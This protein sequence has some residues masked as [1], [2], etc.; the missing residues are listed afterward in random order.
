MK[1]PAMVVTWREPAFALLALLL[2]V[3]A[4]LAVDGA[5]GPGDTAA[6]AAGPGRGAPRA[7]EMDVLLRRIEMRQ[8]SDHPARYAAPAE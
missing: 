8:L 7:V 2:L 4:L 6:G 3:F 1:R 5:F